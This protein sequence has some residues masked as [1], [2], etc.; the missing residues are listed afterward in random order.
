MERHLLDALWA[1][2]R[3]V[4]AMNTTGVKPN[5]HPIFTLIDGLAMRL[6]KES[7]PQ[8]LHFLQNRSYTAARLWLEGRKQEILGCTFQRV[9]TAVEPPPALDRQGWMF[10]RRDL[11]GPSASR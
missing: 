3:T 10:W 2:D 7:S 6:P 11:Q 4:A 1:L 5:L 8:L 9:E